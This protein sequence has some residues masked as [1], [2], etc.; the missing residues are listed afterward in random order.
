[1]KTKTVKCFARCFAGILFALTLN[2]FPAHAQDLTQ[3]V[4]S[5]TQL[6]SYTESILTNSFWPKIIPPGVTAQRIDLGAIPYT[7]TFETNFISLLVGTTNAG[8]C[9][10]SLTA[11]ETN[12]PSHQR[13]WL[14]ATGGVVATWDISYSENDWITNTYG[15]M[16]SFIHAGS[17][18]AVSWTAA[19]SPERLFVTVSLLS[20]NDYPVY[21]ASLTNSAG[22]GADTNGNP[23]PLL[24]LYSNQVAIVGTTLGAPVQMYLHSPTSTVQLGVFGTTNLV[25]PGWQQVASMPRGSDPVLWSYGGL[26]EFNIFTLG[27]MKDTDGDGIPD[28]V[29]ILITHTDPNNPDTDG[30][31]LT[32]GQEFRQYASN[33][34]LFSSSGDGFGDGWKADAGFNPNSTLDP[35][36]VLANGLTAGQ[37]YAMGLPANAPVKSLALSDVVISYKSQHDHI[38]KVGWRQL[39][40]DWGG[41]GTSNGIPRYFLGMTTTATYAWNLYVN[42]D[43]DYDYDSFI[44]TGIVGSGLRNFTSA[45]YVETDTNG[46]VHPRSQASSIVIETGNLAASCSGNSNSYVETVNGTVTSTNTFSGSI[47]VGWDDWSWDSQ[48][49]ANQAF[50]LSGDMT[51]AATWQMITNYIT[52]NVDIYVPSTDTVVSG[53]SEQLFNEYFTTSMIYQAKT[54]LNLCPSMSNLSWATGYKLSNSCGQSVGS[55]SNTAMYYL[56]PHETLF[57]IGRMQYQIRVTNTVTGVVYRVTVEHVFTPYTTNGTLNTSNQS[58]LATFNY[59]TNSLANGAAITLTP[60]NG[61]TVEPPSSNGIVSIVLVQVDIVSDI[62]DD[63]AITQADEPLKI[64]GMGKV[65]LIDTN[66]ASPPPVSDDFLKYTSIAITPTQSNGSVWFTYDTAKVAL[67]YNNG[68]SME[69]IP[70]VGT[71]WFLGVDGNLPDHIYVQG[72]ATT[73]ANNP[74]KI[75]MHVLSGTT[76]FTDTMLCTVT[77]FGHPAYFAGIRDYIKGFR[78]TNYPAIKL[79]EAPI[80]APGGPSAPTHNLVAV[81]MTNVNM[82]IYDARAVGDNSIS[83][84][85]GSKPNSV[86]VANAGYFEHDS[87]YIGRGWN[88]GLMLNSIGIMTN[89]RVATSGDDHYGYRGWI[90]Q[91]TTASF[92]SGTL[93]EPPTNGSMSSALGYVGGLY[94]PYGSLT[95]ASIA[96]TWGS[97]WGLNQ[98]PSNLIGWSSD[99]DVLFIATTCVASESVFGYPFPLTKQYTPAIDFPGFLSKFTNGTA[100]AIFALD[101]G[102]SPALAHK[103]RFGGSIGVVGTPAPRHSSVYPF[104]DIVRDYIVIDWK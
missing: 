97:T 6:W 49:P 100:T 102:G 98:V 81:M 71:F 75:V 32:D 95:F 66:T 73:I 10:F 80:H 40:W 44:F 101:G 12:S 104:N 91:N 57:D 67:W 16:P 55:A 93:A 30:D 26:E 78:E 27:D 8:V 34:T 2:Y 24:S 43:R 82:S 4:Q 14:N 64:S 20:T 77:D 92:N 13:L 23:I 5:T 94:P 99:N 79:Y 52:T 1:M 22:S 61:V 88:I 38:W 58:V 96:S 21:L 36:T 70:N 72:V 25:S 17:T 41:I 33:P 9:Q 47:Q 69:S 85:I 87:T 11:I 19:R 46:Y 18:D 76:E 42:N 51:V 53:M 39:D 63:K 68:G 65:I 56:S 54:E 103:D 29:E 84:V 89:C 74:T 48:W 62:N 7:G 37:V 15:A 45:S 60:T 83:A 28:I 59:F 31:G 35:N 90:G 86:I 3:P 50:T